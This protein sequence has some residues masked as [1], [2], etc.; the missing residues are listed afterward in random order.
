MSGRRLLG[1]S[2]SGG[3]AVGHALVLRD[4]EADANGG[5]GEAEQRRALEALARVGVELG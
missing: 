4:V 5:G 1:L 2:A 3:V